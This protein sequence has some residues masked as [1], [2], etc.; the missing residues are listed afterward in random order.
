[1]NTLHDPNILCN[2]YLGCC[3]YTGTIPVC[4]R[5]ENDQ[6]YQTQESIGLMAKLKQANSYLFGLKGSCLQESVKHNFTSFIVRQ[7]VSEAWSIETLINANLHT[8]NFEFDAALVCLS[9]AV[10]QSCGF[11]PSRLEQAIVLFHSRH[12]LIALKQLDIILEIEPVSSKIQAFRQNIL[13]RLAPHDANTTQTKIYPSKKDKHLASKC[14]DF[15]K[16][17]TESEKLRRKVYNIK[18]KC[19][20]EIKLNGIKKSNDKICGKLF[21]IFEL[22]RKRKI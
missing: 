16:T 22:L 11:L 2:K 15:D 14:T 10:N 6:M 17:L 4:L 13:S 1:M 20:N 18:T 5:L 8:K 12:Y 19:R 3:Q 9:E 7:L 21:E